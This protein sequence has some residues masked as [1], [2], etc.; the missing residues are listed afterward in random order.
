MDKV[1]VSRAVSLLLLEMER[2]ERRSNKRDCRYSKLYGTEEDLKIYAH[3]PM[4]R[5]YEAKPLVG[6]STEEPHLPPL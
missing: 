3:V 4:A 5:A 6:F 2:I 1:R